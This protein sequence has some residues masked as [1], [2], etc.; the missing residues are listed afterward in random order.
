M[1]KFSTIT[2][3]MVM[4]LTVSCSNDMIEVTDTATMNNGSNDIVAQMS[5]F[6]DSLSMTKPE[7]R[8]A[9]RIL[10]WMCVVSSDIIGGYS[11]GCA[12]AK[13]GAIIGHPHVGAA[14]GAVVVGG[15]S[16]YKAHR[17]LSDAYA[18]RGVEKNNISLKPMEVAAA[19][20]PALENEAVIKD[21]YPTQIKL[22]NLDK[23][24]IEIGAKHNAI[25]KNLETNNF[26]KE[27]ILQYLSKEELQ[28][29]SSKELEDEME[30]TVEKTIESS[31][32]GEYIKTDGNDT[33][34][35]VM[36]LFF[37]IFEKYPDNVD[38]VQFI[39]NKYIEAVK[40]TEE[41]S[42]ADKE[43]IYQA[44]SIGASSY[45]YWSGTSK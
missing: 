38:D 7:T 37:E 6:N 18:T 42:E 10:Y 35:K 43:I 30:N 3:G 39:I 15:Y 2:L 12:G 13:V 29:L 19:Y 34:A 17:I 36:N 32:K 9:G 45:E 25:L 40:N 33:P 21:N 4:L 27:K 22:D 26:N 8:G 41:I 23:K 16:S 11:G 24:D 20:V 5:H 14:I 1:K 28:I 44:L 31:L